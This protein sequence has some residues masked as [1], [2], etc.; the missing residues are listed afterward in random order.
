MP[1]SK[2]GTCLCTGAGPGTDARSMALGLI[3]RDKKLSVSSLDPTVPFK[4]RTNKG[5][6]CGDINSLPFYCH[7]LETLGE[8]CHQ[9]DV[10]WVRLG[11]LILSVSDRPRRTSNYSFGER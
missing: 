9:R 5:Q 3:F 8:R 2:T 7:E 6:R 11:E 10:W 1:R 4:V